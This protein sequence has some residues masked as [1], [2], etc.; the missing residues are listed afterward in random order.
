MGARAV[1][2]TGDVAHRAKQ[3]DLEQCESVIGQHGRAFVEVGRAL[4]KIRENELYKERGFKTFEAY[5][6]KRWE[7]NRAHANRLI[8]AFYLLEKLDPKG[9]IPTSETH[10]RPLLKLPEDKRAKVWEM[11]VETAPDGKVTARHVA[12]T[13][14]DHLPAPPPKPRAPAQRAEAVDGDEVDCR[15]PIKRFASTCDELEAGDA[16]EQIVESCMRRLDRAK[17]TQL[18]LTLRILEKRILKDG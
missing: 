6:R 2:T 13:V 7:M 16:I 12:K 11:A 9:S 18:R 8:G 3:D 4:S 15:P 14:T 1:S 10:V 17:L 5:C